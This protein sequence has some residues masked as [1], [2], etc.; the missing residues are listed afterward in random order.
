MLKRIL[1]VV[2]TL[3]SLFVTAQQKKLDYD[4]VFKNT[5]TGIYAPLPIFVRW[6]DNDNAV[7]AERREGNKRPAEFILNIATGTKTVLPDSLLELKQAE[8]LLD[9]AINATN[10][11]NQMMIAFTQKNN[12]YIKQVGTNITKQLT[13]DGSDVILNGYASWIYYEEILGRQSR[14]KAFWWS[15]NS[16]YLAFMR[17]D[18]NEVPMFPIYVNNGQHGYTEKTR[19][20]KVGDKNPT[21]KIGIVEVETGNITWANF[22]DKEDQYFGMPYFTPNNELWV[23]WMNRGQDELTIFQIDKKSGAKTLVYKEQQTTWIDLDDTDRIEFLSNGKQFILKS[24]KS[25]WYQYYLHDISGKQIN[26]ITNGNFTV[27]SIVKIDQNKLFFTAR[28]EHSARWDFYSVQ[29]DGKKLQRHSFG[30]FS[31]SNIQLS[32]KNDYFI[33]NYSNTSNPATLAVVDLKGN[34]KQVIAS[35]KGE[36]FNQYELPKKE[37][38]TVTSNDGLFQLPIV[39]TYP[40]NF[41]S[42]KKYPVLMNVYGGPNAGRVYDTWNTSL[43]DIWWAQEGLIQISADNR[44]SGH[45][46]KIGMSYIHRQLGIY[47]IEDFM[48]VGKWI[49]Q[50]SWSDTS[51]LCIT[52]GSFGGYMTCMALTYGASVFNYGIANSSVTDWKLYDTH[53]TERFMDTPNEN[54][55]GYKKTSVLQYANM[56]KG[57]IRI[58]HGTSDDNVHQQNSLQ[59]IDQLQNFKKH[60]EFMLYPGERHS[61]QELKGLHNR[62][63]A[64]KFYYDNL[65]NKPMPISFWK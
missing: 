49:K 39:I 12:L 5:A 44:S 28:K 29:L 14:Y 57:L 10:S 17:F 21:V 6:I 26:T 31:F 22:N 56:Y 51:K 8:K 25:G 55:E 46:G 36:K 64:Y 9:G 30:N 2:C 38:L 32:L 50:Q 58:V 7:F 54:P 63:E 11:P 34:I 48:A 65:L 19:Y 37:Y 35:A 61:L 43:T 13:F 27:G 1:I 45:F 53:Y 47:E 40:I 16:K 41:N 52:G 33:A 60:F 62:T 4:A 23:Q 15:N 24:D 20:P 42:S 3:T 59:L 18:D